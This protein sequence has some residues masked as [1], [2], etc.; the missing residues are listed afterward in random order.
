MGKGSTP[1]PIKNRKKYDKNFERIFCQSTKDSKVIYPQ[2]KR[3]LAIDPAEE[4][5]ND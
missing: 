4:D 3:I 1:R 5:Y 2:D